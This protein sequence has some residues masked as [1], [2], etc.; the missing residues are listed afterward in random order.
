MLSGA[1]AFSPHPGP[2]AFGPQSSTVGAMNVEPCADC[3]AL[4]EGERPREPRRKR[5]A[6][7]GVK[8]PLFFPFRRELV[9]W[10]FLAVRVGSVLFGLVRIGSDLSA[11]PLFLS[12]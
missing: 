10:L 5:S 3:R 8:F 12:Y 1:R 9:V 2:R 6:A 11:T 7:T 4:R